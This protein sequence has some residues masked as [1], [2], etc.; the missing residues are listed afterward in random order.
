[1][2]WRNFNPKTSGWLCSWQ[3]SARM[4]YGQCGM[5]SEWHNT[6]WIH[7][8]DL[9]S[10]GISFGWWLMAD[11]VCHPDDIRCY[12]KPSGWHNDIWVSH[13]DTPPPPPPPR[14]THTRLSHL[15]EISAFKCPQLAVAL[16]CFRNIRNSQ[17]PF[18]A[19]V[20]NTANTPPAN[21]LSVRCDMKVF[22][23]NI[24]AFR[25]HKILRRY[26]LP[27]SGLGSGVHR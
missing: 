18:T 17:W 16:H 8:D 15:D 14:H 11:A 5:S 3:Y 12:L 13:L 9:A 25:L 1:M 7:L 23:S 24:A 27:H 4:T 6:I 2:T 26:V 21:N 20:T 10:S 19:Y 22:A